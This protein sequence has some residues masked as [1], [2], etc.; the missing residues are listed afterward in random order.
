[1]ILAGKRVLLRLS[2]EGRAA[3]RGLVP[4]GG[5]FEKFV[6]DQDDL[7]VWVLM[8]NEGTAGDEAADRVLLIKWHHFATATLIHQPGAPVE[9]MPV[10]FRP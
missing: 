6:V 5:A 9:R 8:L 3:L 4:D 2:E 10:G 7:G 1:M